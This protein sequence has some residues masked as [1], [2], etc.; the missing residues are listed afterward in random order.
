M[1]VDFGS[2]YDRSVGKK[3]GDFLNRTKIV[4]N[5]EQKYC[6]YKFGVDPAWHI[7]SNELAF[8]NSLKMKISVIFGVFQMV[9]G[10]I[11]KGCNAIHEKEFSEFIFIFLPQLIMMLIMFGYMDFLIFVKWNTT[12]ECNFLAPDIKGYLMSIFS[13]YHSRLTYLN[14]FNFLIELF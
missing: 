6:S 12:Y 8:V 2:C 4:T 3:E 7:S 5:T 11:L 1:P 9:I 10:I 14:F 13:H